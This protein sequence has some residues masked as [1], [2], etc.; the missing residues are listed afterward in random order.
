[1]TQYQKPLKGSSLTSNL[2]NAGENL[3]DASVEEDKVELKVEPQ[4]I[5]DN[6]VEN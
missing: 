2:D 4:A 5:E 3:A 1:M 6:V